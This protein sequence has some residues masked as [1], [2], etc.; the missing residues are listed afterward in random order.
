MSKDW[1]FTF[2]FI[3]LIPKSQSDLGLNKFKTDLGDWKK[4]MPKVWHNYIKMYLYRMYIINKIQL[5]GDNAKSILSKLQNTS[6]SL[7]IFSKQ[8]RIN[9]QTFF[10]CLDSVGGGFNW[11]NE[12]EECFVKWEVGHFFLATKNLL[13]P[14]FRCTYSHLQCAGYA[15]WKFDPR[16]RLNITFLSFYLYGGFLRKLVIIQGFVYH[17][18]IEESE[19]DFIFR[20]QHSAFNF[21]SN[22][23]MVT[24]CVVQDIYEILSQDQIV[25]NFMIFDRNLFMNVHFNQDKILCGKARW[26]WKDCPSTDKFKYYINNNKY[27]LFRYNIYV[28]KFDKI[29]ITSRSHGFLV[30]DGPGYLSHAMNASKNVIITSTFQCLVLILLTRDQITENEHFNFTSKILSTY[31]IIINVTNNSMFYIPKLKYKNNLCISFFLAESGNEVNITP[32]VVKST[33]PYNINCLYAGLFAG[34]RLADDYQESQTICEDNYGST[35]QA[36]SL[37]SKN[38]SLI[39][40]MYCYKEYGNISASVMVSQTKCKG[41]FINPCKF[42]MLCWGNDM[43]KCQSYLDNVT[44]FSNI[45]MRIQSKDSVIYERNFGKCSVLQISSMLTD[46]PKS[47]V[48][49]TTK[50]HLLKSCSL[51]LTPNHRVNISVKLSMDK[52]NIIII[53]RKI[54]LCKNTKFCLKNISEPSIPRMMKYKDWKSDYNSTTQDASLKVIFNYVGTT[55]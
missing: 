22:S 34:E 13:Y 55:S 18:C 29:I 5:P 11:H 32:I 45:H 49:Y 1:M 4:D 16:L 46:F 36:M 9:M 21:Y 51:T 17:R 6:E 24:M 7:L 3:I 48:P 39:L 8:I 42:N 33:N 26:Q 27:E 53:D 28:S 38:S 25:G 15:Y 52:N 37:Y 20:G 14:Y 50:T 30:F 44:R 2:I 35:G 47:F 12:T 43:I 19:N 41:L 10:M 40:I 54:Y 23:R 31:D